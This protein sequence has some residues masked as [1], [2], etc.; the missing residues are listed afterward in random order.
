M[1]HRLIPRN[2]SHQE[3]ALSTETI[4]I[5]SGLLVFGSGVPYAYRVMQGVIQ[6][7]IVSWGVWSVIGLAI[8]LTYSSSGATDNI[9]PAVFGFIVPVVITGL[10]LWRG[11]R[12]K[13]ELWEIACGCIGVLGIVWWWFV[14]TDP[15]QAQ[16]ALYLAIFADLCA[17]VPTIIFVLNNPGDDRP[18][19]WTMY[20]VGYGLAV[21]AITEHTFANYVL[22]IYMLLGSGTIATILAVHRIKKGSPLS[23]WA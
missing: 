16:F 21:F 17:A 7:N 22:P 11:L 4:G 9:W 1:R 12:H 23:Q 2:Q 3:V 13:P 14:Q 19:A 8:L 5:L 18:L 20:G 15:S 6:P 10:A